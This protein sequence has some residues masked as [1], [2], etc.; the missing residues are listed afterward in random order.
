MKKLGKFLTSSLVF[1]LTIILFS[2][3]PK[4]DNP[5]PTPTTTSGR[6]DNMALGNPS[7]ATTS[8]SNADNYLMVKPQYVLSYNR[9]KAT[10]NW[11][12]WHLNKSWKGSAVRKDDFRSDADLP[13]SWDKVTSSD[14]TST[15]FDRGHICPS[16]DRDGS[17][18]D[19]SATFYMTNML[20]QAPQNNRTTWRLLEEYCRD[21]VFQNNSE[22]YIISGGYGTGGSGSEGGTTKTIGSSNVNVPARVWKVILILPN[23]SNDISRITSSTRVIAVDMPNKESVTDKKW[24][25]YRVSVND[26]ETKTNLNFFNSVSTSI[27]SSIESKIDTQKI[28]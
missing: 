4:T 7:N 3:E 21:L 26:I 2:C 28:E 15:G 9:S 5:T 19:N 13:S 10:A 1:S 23:G 8:T 25:E 18:E 20:P 16:D 22:L 6:D 12:S 14:Y 24:Y 17:Q 27:Q 11:V